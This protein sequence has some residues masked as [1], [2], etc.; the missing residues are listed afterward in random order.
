MSAT[1]P[2]LPKALRLAPLLLL[3]LSL[4]GC[5]HDE[6][7]NHA[8]PSAPTELKTK[9]QITEVH[10][11]TLPVVAA[12][13]GSVITSDQVSVSSRVMGYVHS[14]DVHE[15]QVVKAGQTL[16][17]ID[18]AD[19]TGAIGQAQ[20]GVGK[21]LA[22]LNNAKANYERYRALFQENAVPK[23]VFEQMQT[24]YKVAQ[25]NYTAAQSALEQ[26]KAQLTY[27]K[28]TAPFAGTITSRMVDAGQMAYP[29]APLMVLQGGGRKQVEVQLNNQAFATIKVGEP[30]TIRYTDFNGNKHQFQGPV[31]RMVEATDPISHTHTVKIGIP[32]N[33]DVRSGNYVEVTVVVDH[34][35]GITI[36]ISALHNRGGLAGVF[37]VDAHDRA[38]FR[39][40][41]PG[42]ILQ[43][44]QVIL[45][46]LQPGER[47]VTR[48]DDRLQ[49][50]ILIEAAP[51]SSQEKSSS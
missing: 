19:V 31:E 18:S 40:V 21:A 48:A 13:P 47:V 12:F 24:A 46:G 7:T 3:S 42:Q 30:I 51:V 10:G 15:G 11:Q 27:V 1:N 20:A 32:D 35:P 38:W 16:L 41:R 33:I 9:G 25:S 17:T 49:N 39:M 29:S 8:S 14:V 43:D 26:A 22:G 4:A 6:T 45:A 2:N 36:P 34:E 23:Q 37:V 5:G 28:I 44:R 50:G